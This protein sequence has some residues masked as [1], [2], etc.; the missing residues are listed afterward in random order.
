[1]RVFRGMGMIIV[2]LALIGCIHPYKLEVRQGNVVTKEMIATLKPGMTKNQVQF[3]LGT[4]L[5]ADPFHPERWDYVYVY[6]KNASAPAQ[7]R[8][9]TVIFDGDTMTRLEGD[10]APSREAAPTEPRSDVAGSG[11]ERPDTSLPPPTARSR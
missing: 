8:K 11:K 7:T 6:K 9:L 3:V 10:L 4:P 2:L 1:M 5:I